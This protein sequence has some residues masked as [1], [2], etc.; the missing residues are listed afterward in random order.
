MTK[1]VHNTQYFCRPY[2]ITLKA[3]GGG[4]GRCSVLFIDEKPSSQIYSRSHTF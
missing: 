2:Q 1:N 4:E 3:P